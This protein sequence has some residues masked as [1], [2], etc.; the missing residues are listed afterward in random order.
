MPITKN[1][2]YFIKLVSDWHAVRRVD[3]FT[4]VVGRIRYGHES[5]I[6]Y[7]FNKE[8]AV[9]IKKALELLHKTE[10]SY[11]EAMD[12]VVGH[13]VDFSANELLVLKGMTED[14]ELAQTITKM[15]KER[16]IAL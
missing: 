1:D 15:A 4:H 10:M 6:A 11:I 3:G 8:D 5:G 2:K 12:G 13:L 7:T 16:G 9:Q 14:P